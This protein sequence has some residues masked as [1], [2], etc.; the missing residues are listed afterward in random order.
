MKPIENQLLEL[1]DN[2][3]K[4]PGMYLGNK[5][6]TKLHMYL[7]GFLH[8][9]NILYGGERCLK[10]FK[11]FQE[12]TEMKYDITSSHH[13]SS[14]IRFYSNDE[15]CA[16]DIFYENL[17][18]FLNL[19]EKERDYTYIIHKKERWLKIKEEYWSR[20]SDLKENI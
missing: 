17:Y 14:I 18:E 9:S 8:A 5:S 19:D 6:I 2:I 11:G 20:I 4:K 7:E 16:F 3:K 10:F 15:S 12:W 13:W 1:L